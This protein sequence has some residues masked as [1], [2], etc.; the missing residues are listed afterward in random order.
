[1]VLADSFFAHHPNGSFTVLV[2]DDEERLL[3]LDN[4][5][6]NW[7]R[8][9][10]IG[11]D[12]REIHRLAGIYEV[13]ELATAVKPV[14]LRR[15]LDEGHDHVVYLDPD[16]RIYASLADLIPL[17]HRHGIVLTPHTTRPYPR[18]DKRIDGF[19]VLA[20]GVYNLGFV[21]IGSNPRPLPQ[22][23]GRPPRPDACFVG[24]H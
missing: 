19:F 8:L 1:R 6:I 7:R 13:T 20:A 3:T 21:A 2:I 22:R 12:Q 9:S 14:L 24:R 23:W 11:L 17:A 18:D 16:I 15:L 4:G 5:P 10:D